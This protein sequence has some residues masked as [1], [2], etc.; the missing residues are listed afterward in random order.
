GDY[1]DGKGPAR[2][3]HPALF[4]IAHGGVYLRLHSTLGDAQPTLFMDGHTVETIPPVTLPDPARQR[5]LRE[6]AHV[7]RVHVPA[8]LDG[9][10]VA[11]GRHGD[12]QGWTF[13]SAAMGVETP[14]DFGLIEQTNIAYAGDRAAL[15]VVTTDIAGREAKGLL[16]PFRAEGAALDEPVRVPTQL[17]LPPNPRAC[18]PAD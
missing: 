13:E 5:G 11:L 16:Y 3:A 14:S 15:L 9:A 18:G 8:W 2:A 12:R 17:D 1:T 7:G 6:M 4:S 10:T